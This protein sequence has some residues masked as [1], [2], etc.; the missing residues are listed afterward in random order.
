MEHIASSFEPTPGTRRRTYDIIIYRWPWLTSVDFAWPW[1][2]SVNF[3][4]VVTL[5]ESM[6]VTCEHLSLRILWTRNAEVHKFR[7]RY[8]IAWDANSAWH[9]LENQVTGQVI[10]FQLLL[11]QLSSS[12]KLGIEIYRDDRPINTYSPPPNGWCY[13]HAYTHAQPPPPTH[14]MVRVSTTMSCCSLLQDGLV[15]GFWTLVTLLLHLVELPEW[16]F[17]SFRRWVRLRSDLL[18]LPLW[19]QQSC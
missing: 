18:P 9:D 3:W 12:W 15:D 11:G 19:T 8:I 7:R 16:A 1:F 14:T 17:G 4:K 5:V 13:P 6:N 2:I 10:R